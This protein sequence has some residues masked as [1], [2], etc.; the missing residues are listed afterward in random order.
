MTDKLYNY[1]F[2][3]TIVIDVVRFFLNSMDMQW[4]KISFIQ[5]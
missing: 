4:N 3:T 1:F 5:L 2:Q